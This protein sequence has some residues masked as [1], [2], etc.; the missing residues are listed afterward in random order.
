MDMTDVSGVMEAA[1]QYHR[2]SLHIYV[3]PEVNQLCASMP[4]TKHFACSFTVLFQE[5]LYTSASNLGN[6]LFFF[7]TRCC[8]VVLT[9]VCAQTPQVTSFCKCFPISQLPHHTKFFVALP[10]FGMLPVVVLVP[11]CQRIN[12]EPL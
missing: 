3:K 11:T 1:Q 9:N 4:L 7:L 6:D 12:N 8:K 2:V 5:H 10:V